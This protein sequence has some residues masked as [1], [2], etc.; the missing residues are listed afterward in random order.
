LPDFQLINQLIEVQIS[1]DNDGDMQEK[2]SAG[3]R[4][5]NLNVR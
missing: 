1:T 4:S 2:R 5:Y 3:G